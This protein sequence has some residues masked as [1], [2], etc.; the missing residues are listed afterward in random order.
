MYYVYILRLHD[1]SLYIGYS[2]D[3][4]QRLVEHQKG[5]V[6]STK[7]NLPSVLIWYSAFRSKNQAIAFEKYMKSSSGFAFQNKHLI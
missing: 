5:S 1:R 4:K 2:S 6:N 7:H 3:L